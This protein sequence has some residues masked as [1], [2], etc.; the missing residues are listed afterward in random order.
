MTRTTSYRIL[1]S[2]FPLAIA[3]LAAACGPGSDPA[4]PEP[5]A[6]DAG[7]DPDVAPEL[8]RRATYLAHDGAQNRFGAAMAVDGDTMVVGTETDT[9]GFGAAY[10]FT[11]G[12][13]GWD[14]DVTLDAG[15]SDTFFGYR[16]ALDGDTLAV[17]YLRRDDGGIERGHVRTFTRTDGVWSPEQEL[18]VDGV[19][20]SDRF[21]LGLALDGDTLVVGDDELSFVDSTPTV[22]VFTRAD[23]QWSVTATLTAPTEQAGF[24]GSAVAVEGDLLL[25]GAPKAV[26]DGNDDRTGLAHLYR[27]NDTGY[28]LEAV[29]RHDFGNVLEHDIDFGEIVRLHDGRA[30]VA[31]PEGGQC[32]TIEEFTEAQP[33]AWEITQ[34][35]DVGHNACGQ[36]LH[37]DFVVAGDVLAIGALGTVTDFGTIDGAAYVHR[38]EGGAWTAEG[39]K[40]VQEP[41]TPAPGASVALSADSVLLGAPADHAVYEF[42]F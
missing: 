6:V 18:V 37:M 15:D 16:V 36:S 34:S 8:P 22:Y 31:A 32:G 21:G 12:D 38:R 4:E 14:A 27:R 23:G 5:P 19:D 10:V 11:R 35:I 9:N 25:V 1:S 13:D 17:A 40:F 2:L 20:V 26:R 24:Y 7:Q 39:E 29:L 3:S 42:G 28:Q 41:E 30:Y 33:F